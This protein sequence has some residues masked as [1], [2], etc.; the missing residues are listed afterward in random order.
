MKQVP[1]VPRDLLR[2]RRALLESEPSWL[3]V[4]LCGPIWELNLGRAPKVD[5]AIEPAAHTQSWALNRPTAHL[6][7]SAKHHKAGCERRQPQD[8]PKMD[9]QFGID[10]EV[11]AGS[12][13]IPSPAV[14]HMDYCI[15]D[16]CHFVTL[17]KNLNWIMTEKKHRDPRP[18]PAAVVEAACTWSAVLHQRARSKSRMGRRSTRQKQ[19]NDFVRQ[20]RFSAARIM[21]LPTQYGVGWAQHQAPGPHAKRGPIY[22]PHRTR[23]CS[24]AGRQ[25]KP[26]HNAASASHLAVA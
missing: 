23:P 9:C 8:G 19:S 26:A 25:D 12:A 18:R 16:E 14:A 7:F 4:L 5:Q 11:C 1:L 15:C 6:D 17:L 20:S 10:V 24:A 21:E 22:G 3:G 13:S 2:Y